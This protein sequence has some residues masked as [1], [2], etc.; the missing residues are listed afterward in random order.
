MAIAVTDL[1]GADRRA[2]APA[3]PDALVAAVR[4]VAAARDLPGV[5][6]AVR[7]NARRLVSADGATFVLREGP[8]VHY[9]DEDAISPL[10]KGR[11]FPAEACASVNRSPGRLPPVVT[12]S[13]ANPRSHRSAT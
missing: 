5:M 3:A 11:R 12:T 8:V 7:R 6:A 4:E 2:A 1:S 10:W 9:A 13:G